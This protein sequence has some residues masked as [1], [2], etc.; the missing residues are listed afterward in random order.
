MALSDKA[1]HSAEH[2]KEAAAEQKQ[3]IAH[4]AEK[5]EAAVKEGRETLHERLQEAE[6]G[7]VRWHH[8][9]GPQPD[10]REWC[11]QEYR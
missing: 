10:Q 7:D 11:D 4:A 3:R 5:A 2:A 6:E 8:L 9:T 1:K